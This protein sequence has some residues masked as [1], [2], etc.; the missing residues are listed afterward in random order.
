MKQSLPSAP[1]LVHPLISKF[2]IAPS[3]EPERAST[4]KES[5]SE[6]FSKT[7]KTLPLLSKAV[8]LVGLLG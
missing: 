1:S 2:V 3:V 5:P 8:I 7:P 4:V 6:I